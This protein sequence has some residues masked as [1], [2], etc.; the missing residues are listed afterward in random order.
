M[1]I[2]HDVKVGN[3]RARTLAEESDAL[4]VKSGQSISHTFAIR[5]R[6]MEN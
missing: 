1:F 6:C 4:P 5:L 3:F 2:S